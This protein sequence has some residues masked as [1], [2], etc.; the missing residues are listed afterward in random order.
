M[1]SGV[2]VA[3]AT[4]ILEVTLQCLVKL[5]LNCSIHNLAVG[6]KKCS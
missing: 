6:L 3:M 4:T 1:K 2:E 5:D